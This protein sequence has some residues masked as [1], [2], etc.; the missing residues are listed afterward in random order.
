MFH[1]SLCLFFLLAVDLQLGIKKQCGWRHAYALDL[2]YMADCIW[3]HRVRRVSVLDKSLYNC[4]VL[5]G[6]LT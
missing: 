2:I 3:F 6:R 1:V 4:R 5:D